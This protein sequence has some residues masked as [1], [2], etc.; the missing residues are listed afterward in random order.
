MVPVKEDYYVGE[1]ITC[2]ATGYPV[3]NYRW[4]AVQS[5]GARPVN[6]SKLEITGKVFVIIFLLI[7][8]SF[9]LEEHYVGKII[10]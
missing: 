8:V 2:G 9:E 5:P 10:T 1:T 6:G 4:L 7:E 3:P